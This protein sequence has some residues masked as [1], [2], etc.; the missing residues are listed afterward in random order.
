MTQVHGTPVPTHPSL[1]LPRRLAAVI[2]ALLLAL[3]LTTAGSST[4]ASADDPDPPV[5][6]VP[7]RLGVSGY[8]LETDAVADVVAG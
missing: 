4:P 7:D 1:A 8:D 6:S 5:L 2:L 3:V